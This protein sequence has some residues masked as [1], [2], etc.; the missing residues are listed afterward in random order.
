VRPLF[1]AM[2]AATL[3]GFSASPGI[4]A[5][6]NTGQWIALVLI[7]FG[8]LFTMVVGGLAVI[9]ICRLRFTDRDI[10]WSAVVVETVAVLVGTALL[11]DTDRTPFQALFLA[12]SSF[13]NCGQYISTLPNSSLVLVHA[14]IL[15]LS[16]LGGLGLPVLMEM[17]CFLVFR[18]ELSA[19]SSC[20]IA[21]SA[22]LYVIGLVLLLSL[23]LA[24]HGRPSWAEIKNQVPADSVLSVE[25]RTGGMEIAPMSAVSQPARWVLIVLMMIGAN[26]AGTASGLKASTLVELADGS[27]RLLRG[28]AVGR[29]FAIAFVWLA[30]YLGLILAAVLLLTYVSGADPGDNILFNAVSGLSNVGFT[31]QPVP[32][33]KG[34][35]FAYCA[36]ILVGR[37]AP[38]MVLWWMAETTADAELAIG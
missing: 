28:Q 12:A 34:V 10:I 31:A 7:I 32:D 19:H 27:R 17:W 4:S 1:I 5:L 6:N 35:L 22:W 30:I 16:I 21:A 2:N 37:M 14:V 15:P 29:S 20:A 11:W 36:I 23:N 25:S 9:R 18:A 24:G 38:L 13:G 26:S 3:S 33:Q 8:S